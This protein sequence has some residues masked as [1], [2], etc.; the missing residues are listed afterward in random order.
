MSCV[1]R[2][3]NTLANATHTFFQQRGF[4]YCHAPI[5]TSSDCEGAGELLQITTLLPGPG[6]KVPPFSGATEQNIEALKQKIS[7]LGSKVKELKEA[8]AEQAAVEASVRELKLAKDELA[9]VLET[10]V[11]VGGVPF[12]DDTVNYSKDFFRSAAYLTVSGQLQAEAFACSM[13]NT[14]TFGPTFR[15]ENSNT[16][17]HLSEFWMIEP[18]IAFANLEVSHYFYF[19]KEYLMLPRMI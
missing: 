2:I 12:K 5:I 15:A 6:S 16:V 4:L 1:F 18:E 11:L 13:S 10:G 9:K 14:Y 17:R 7:E 3:R 8:K 19:L